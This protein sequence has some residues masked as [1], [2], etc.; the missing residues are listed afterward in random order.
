M[1]QDRF[2]INSVQN[3]DPNKSLHIPE[4]THDTQK[5]KPNSDCFRSLKYMIYGNKLFG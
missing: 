5:F 2:F 1:S 4:I 3:V